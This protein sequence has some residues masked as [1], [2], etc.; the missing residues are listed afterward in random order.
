[1]YRPMTENHFLDKGPTLLIN[2]YT[3]NDAH[4]VSHTIVFK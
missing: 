2:N 3:Y 4:T 1:M